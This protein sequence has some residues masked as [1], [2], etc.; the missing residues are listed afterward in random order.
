MSPQPAAKLSIHGDQAA[1][2]PP[3]E[4]LP[5]IVGIAPPALPAD[6][7]VSIDEGAPASVMRRETLQRRLLAVADVLAVTATLLLVLH[8][9]H[10]ASLLPLAPFSAVRELYLSPLWPGWLDS[11]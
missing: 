5:V 11:E 3:H 7:A 10:H 8:G 9:S 1:A 6:N 2:I 4:S